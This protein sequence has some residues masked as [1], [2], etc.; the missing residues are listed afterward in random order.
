[1]LETSE[2]DIF[3]DPKSSHLKQLETQKL[4]TILLESEN[5]YI[6]FQSANW[7]FVSFSSWYKLKSVFTEP[8]TDSCG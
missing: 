1:M 8:N 3:S 6:F 5:Y 4:L 2:L 7:L